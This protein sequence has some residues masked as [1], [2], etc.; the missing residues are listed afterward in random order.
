MDQEEGRKQGIGKY[1][2][3]EIDQIVLCMNEEGIM[4]PTSMYNQNA[5]IKKF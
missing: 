5:P 2:G 3:T 1:W 4:N